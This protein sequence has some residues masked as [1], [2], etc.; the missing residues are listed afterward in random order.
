LI[1]VNGVFSL[2]PFQGPISESC[3]CRALSD[4]EPGIKMTFLLSV[5]GSFA[6]FERRSLIRERQREGIALAKKRGAYR[7]RTKSL[8]SDQIASLQTRVLAGEKKAAIAREFRISR[9]TLYQYLKAAEAR[10]PC[11][12]L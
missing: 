1:F 3:D 10:E 2:K 4:A 12:S 7:G 5:M 11:L 9:E 8:S 6:E